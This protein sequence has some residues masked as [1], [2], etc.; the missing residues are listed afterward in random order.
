MGIYLYAKPP[1]TLF[2][3][4]FKPLSDRWWLVVK[5]IRY[6]CPHRHPRICVLDFDVKHLATV[7]ASG[8]F[9][10]DAPPPQSPCAF[11][12]VCV[13]SEPHTGTC[14]NCGTNCISRC[15]SSCDLR[16]NYSM[17]I[18]CARTFLLLLLLTVVVLC[19]V[20]CAQYCRI[21]WLS[22]DAIC[23]SGRKCSRGATVRWR[24]M[25][26]PFVCFVV[27]WH[28]IIRNVR[29]FHKFNIF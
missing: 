27:S 21:T 13:S 12:C 18:K 29:D 16:A 6:P 26:P 10:G 2:D 8:R 9:L 28:L 22:L 3:I 20:K 11:V 1:I 19:A 24:V 25:T 15:A 14:A 5:Q 23:R 4:Q 7:Y 17:Q